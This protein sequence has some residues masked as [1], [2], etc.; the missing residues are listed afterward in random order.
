MH[1]ARNLATDPFV[2]RRWLVTPHVSA[3]ACACVRACVR[4][5]FGVCLCLWCV[6]VRLLVR[7][8]VSACQVVRLLVRRIDSLFS[9]RQKVRPPMQRLLLRCNWEHRGKHERATLRCARCVLACWRVVSLHDARSGVQCRRIAVC[10][11]HA[12]LLNDVMR[13][14]AGCHR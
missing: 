2:R 3:Y 10:M 12:A 6:H 11:L 1:T 8:H 13:V 7:I 9:K 5:S 14:D 4:R